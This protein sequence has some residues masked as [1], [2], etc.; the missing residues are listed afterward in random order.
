[1]FRITFQKQD[2][3]DVIEQD[4]Q[5]GALKRLAP[6]PVHPVYQSSQKQ[7]LQDGIKQDVQD[8]ISEAGF[9]GCY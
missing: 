9:T 7:D 2:L 3:Q 1:M 4:F 5:D 6:Y 8:N